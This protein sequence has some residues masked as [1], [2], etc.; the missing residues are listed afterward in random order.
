MLRSPF[1][2]TPEGPWTPEVAWPSTLGLPRVG[3]SLQGWEARWAV[4]YGKLR[5]A[6]DRAPHLLW[7]PSTRHASAG[8]CREHVFTGTLRGGPH[9]PCSLTSAPCLPARTTLP[10]HFVPDMLASKRPSHSRCS[11]GPLTTLLQSQSDVF[12]PGVSGE[13][14]LSKLDTGPSQG[15]PVR[16]IQ[17]SGGWTD[18]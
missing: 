16:I 10:E 1:T 12:L 18:A 7:S 2:L 4:A 6:H 11:A 15:E 5:V 14:G 8:V 9:R 17:W 3:T 13:G